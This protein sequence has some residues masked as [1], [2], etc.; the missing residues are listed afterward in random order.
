MNFI[1]RCINTFFDP[2]RLMFEF[3]LS[4]KCPKNID[5]IFVVKLMEDEILTFKL[6]TENHVAALL[7]S[8]VEYL[9]MSIYALATHSPS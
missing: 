2:K 8:N 6:M 9:D 7:N 5:R 3:T 1:L 4:E